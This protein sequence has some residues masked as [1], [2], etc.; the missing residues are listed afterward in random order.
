M[1][2]QRFHETGWSM[3]TVSCVMLMAFLII[4]CTG[5]T[6]AGPQ[7]VL[8]TMKDTPPSA[9]EGLSRKRVLFGHQSVGNNMLAGLDELL[10][11]HPAIGLTV[12]SITGP[13]E[14]APGTLAHFQVGRNEKALSKIEDFDAKIRQGLGSQVDIALFK[15]CFVD[16]DAGTDVESLFTEYKG[17]M[18]ALRRDYPGVAFVHVTVPLLRKEKATLKGYVKKILGRSDGFFA[19]SHNVKRNQYNELLLRHYAGSEPV[20]DLASIQAAHQDG[21]HEVFTSGGRSYQALAPEYTDD[22]GHLNAL[23]RR[24]VAE[25]F[26]IFLAGL[27]RKSLVKP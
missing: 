2:S 15:F 14:L 6:M 12:R 3:K 10:K 9:W 23:G 25:Q 20:F 13:E 22:G 21:T 24:V 16:V 7:T 26:L 4:S 5:E 11:E 1:R 8:K 19:N 27:D 17:T 18:A